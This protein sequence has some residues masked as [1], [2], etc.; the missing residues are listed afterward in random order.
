MRKIGG[1]VACL[2]ALSSTA[3]AEVYRCINADGEM[4]YSNIAC[5]QDFD[6][7]RLHIDQ[8]VNR[9]GDEAASMAPQRLAD[10]R[11]DFARIGARERCMKRHAS[12]SLQ[13]ACLRN[14]EDG[15]QEMQGG[16]DLPPAAEAEAR[17]RCVSRHESYALQAACMRNEREGWRQMR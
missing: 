10:S 17:A 11:W 7:S 4:V 3:S 13:A 2:M 9:P 5:P 15:Y 1:L 14:E 12:Y 16:F 6:R 8:P